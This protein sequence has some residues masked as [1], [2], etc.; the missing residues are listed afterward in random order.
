MASR[1][2]VK[3]YRIYVCGDQLSDSRVTVFGGVS[4]FT[5]LV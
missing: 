5:R 2:P 3:V 1:N 4:T